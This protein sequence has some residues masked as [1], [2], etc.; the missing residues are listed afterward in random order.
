M[1]EQVKISRNVFGKSS[2]TN[3]VN[4]SFGQLI[5]VSPPVS[6]AP[7]IGVSEFFQYYN[8][9]FYDIPASG[10]YSG[11]AGFSHLDIINRSSDYLGISFTNMEQ[12]ITDLRSE[13]VSLQRQLFTITQTTGSI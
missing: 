13:N 9:L 1:P 8:E 5:P 10:S 3:V 4:T 7:L 2:F 6:E 11:S 12:E